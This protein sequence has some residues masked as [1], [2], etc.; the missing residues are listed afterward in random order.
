[1]LVV[2]RIAT[3]LNKSIICTIHQPSAELFYLFDRLCLL[4]PGG[5]QIFWGN[6]GLRSADFIEYFQTCPG[7]YPLVRGKNPASWL[8]EQSGAGTDLEANKRFVLQLKQFYQQSAICQQAQKQLQLLSSIVIINDTTTNTITTENTIDLRLANNNNNN[9]TNQQ[10]QQQSRPQNN[11]NNNN[12]DKEYSISLTT[13]Y[14]PKTTTQ[15]L[16]HKRPNLFKKFIILFSR[17]FQQYYR[18]SF[19]VAR[20]ITAIFLSLLFGLLYF[21]TEY[22]TQATMMAR[23]SSFGVVLYFSATVASASLPVFELRPI[24]YRESST[25]FYPKFLWATVQFLNE[26][27][28]TLPY[29]LFAAVPL[30]FMNNPP[31]GADKFFLYWVAAYLLILTYTAS[32]LWLTACSA[33]IAAS[34][35]FMSAFLGLSFIFSSLTITVPQTAQGWHWLYYLTPLSK[36]CNLIMQLF[37]DDYTPVLVVKDN[38]PF[39]TTARQFTTDYLGFAYGMGNYAANIGYLFAYIFVVQVFA[40]LATI[41][42]NFEKG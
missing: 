13:Q 5:H 36:C 4:A 8:L 40:H 1:M 7:V 16:L 29:S 34:T 41:F 12:P 17:Q 25:G 38:V 6:L 39:F 32:T 20:L 31:D 2:R 21:G 30:Y 3:V 22:T 28:W 24:F 19:T 18:G 23:I 9:N 11:N 27:I 35:S 15:V 33:S 37:E 26:V 42:F 14:I 10:Q